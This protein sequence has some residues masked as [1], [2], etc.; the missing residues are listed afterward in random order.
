MR[1]AFARMGSCPNAKTPMTTSNAPMEAALIGASADHGT[2][3]IAKKKNLMSM[4]SFHLLKLIKNIMV[5]KNVMVIKNIMII[6]K[7]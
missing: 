4:M 5:I 7:Y 2:L 3:S 1:A 6:K